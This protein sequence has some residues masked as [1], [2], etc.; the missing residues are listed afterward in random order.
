M[1]EATVHPCRTAGDIHL[2][3]DILRH[4]AI[5]VV[6]DALRLLRRRYPDVALVG[7]V[8]NPETLLQGTPADVGREVG[9]CLRCEIE[10]VAPECAVPLTSPTA[11]L[12]AVAEA[13]R[14]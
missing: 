6:L 10:V 14:A 12:R 4:P 11:N 13:A 3:A 2:P 5:V 8:S 1:P 9:E 7:N